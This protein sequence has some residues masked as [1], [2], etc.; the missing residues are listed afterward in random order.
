M[1]ILTRKQGAAFII[2]SD[3]SMSDAP[4]SRPPKVRLTDSL[5]VWTGAAWSNITTEA[6]MFGTLDDADE[7]VRANFAKVSG[8]TSPTKPAGVRKRR[9]VQPPTAMVPATPAESLSPLVAV[10]EPS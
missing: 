8:Q 4:T 2:G 3:R 9:P 5:A 6:L 7:Y 10:T 1:G